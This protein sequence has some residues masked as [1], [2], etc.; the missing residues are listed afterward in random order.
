MEFV[1]LHID[2]PAAEAY[3][4]AFQPQPLFDGRISAQLNLAACAQNAMPGQS[5]RT[6][7]NS[8]NLPRCPGI[9]CPAGDSAV[10]RDFSSRN[11]TN[12]GDDANLHFISLCHSRR[13][14]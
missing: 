9:S 6:M 11:P 14:P 12:C 3:T 7:E 2:S 5:E 8:D 10:S 4:F 1:R 13:S